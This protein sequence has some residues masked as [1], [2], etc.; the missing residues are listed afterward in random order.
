MKRFKQWKKETITKWA[1]IYADIIIEGLKQSYNLESDN[2]WISQ[3]LWL[4]SW[5]VDRDIYLN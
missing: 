5:C 2:F 1:Q 4:D 3:G